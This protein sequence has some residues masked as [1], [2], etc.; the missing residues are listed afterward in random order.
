MIVQTDTDVLF[1]LCLAPGDD[2]PYSEVPLHTLT[3]EPED[4]GQDI[5]PFTAPTEVIYSEL[6]PKGGEM[7]HQG[8]ASSPFTQA[9]QSPTSRSD[10]EPVLTGNLMVTP[11]SKHEEHSPSEAS[12]V[13]EKV[14]PEFNQAAPEEDSQTDALEARVLPTTSAATEG[15]AAVGGAADAPTV[16]TNESQPDSHVTNG[17][18]LEGVV[19]EDLSP[20]L[21]H[22]VTAGEVSCGCVDKIS[23]VTTEGAGNHPTTTTTTPTTAVA[24]SSPSSPLDQDS[25]GL[26]TSEVSSVSDS[27]ESGIKVPDRRVEG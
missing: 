22:V 12:E 4:I 27:G 17:L 14:N 2:G 20:G 26:D 25:V 21:G 9:F 19:P 1:Y 15:A 13:T 10:L 11:S 6:V 5:G 8:Q 18:H 23:A 16:R 3:T 24:P 7:L